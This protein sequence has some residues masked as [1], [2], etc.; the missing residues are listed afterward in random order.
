[1]KKGEKKGLPVTRKAADYVTSDLKTP[2]LKAA[3][4][5]ALSLHPGEAGRAR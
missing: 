3:E 4:V 5:L 2:D 1:M